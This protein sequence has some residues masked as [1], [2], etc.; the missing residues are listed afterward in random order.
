MD[1]K[2]KI[3][4]L[5]VFASVLLLIFSQVAFAAPLGWFGVTANIITAQGDSN[6]SV[7]L[8]GKTEEILYPDRVEYVSMDALYYRNGTAGEYFGKETTTS[9]IA[10]KTKR[11]YEDGNATYDLVVIGYV[12][13]DDD[14]EYEQSTSDSKYVS[15]SCSTCAN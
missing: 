5:I 2:K 4:L 11:V 8:Y 7:D 9:H 14:S 1:L 10:E 3:S 12:R 15:N 6:V 13:Y